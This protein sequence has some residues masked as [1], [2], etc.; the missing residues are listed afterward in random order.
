MQ[1]SFISVKFNRREMFVLF[2]RKLV[3]NKP[4]VVLNALQHCFTRNKSKRQI[5][6]LPHRNSSVV[7]IEVF[8]F[9]F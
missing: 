5:L 1:F 2:L 8:I 3:F 9:E 7:E 6:L 4:K